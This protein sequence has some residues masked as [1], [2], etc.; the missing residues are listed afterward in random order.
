[1]TTVA[2]VQRALIARGFDV[3]KAGADGMIG[4]A[5][6]AAVMLSLANDPVKGAAIPTPTIRPEP[7]PSDW[8]PWAKM[9]RIIVHWSAGGNRASDLDKSHYHMI[10]EGDGKIVRGKPTILLNQAPVK[11]GYAAHT[12]NCNSGSVG[13]SLAGMAGAIQSPF[14]AGKSPIT[15]AQWD[16]LMPALAQIARRYSIPV[17]AGTI[18]SHAEVQSTLGIT[19]RGKWDIAILPFDLSKNTAAKVGAEMRARVSAL[20]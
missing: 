8:L 19:Q 1:M 12:L 16:A 9:D 15:K 18:L 17:T 11:S 7:I 14:T 4:P 10:I 2:E 3:G 6:L 13:I 5:T 20:I